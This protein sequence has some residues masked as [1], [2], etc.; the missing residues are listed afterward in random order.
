[1][2]LDKILVK[3]ACRTLSTYSVLSTS[4]QTAC[5]GQHFV[6]HHEGK[7]SL[8][9]DFATVPVL[10]AKFAIHQVKPQAWVLQQ[11]FVGLS[12]AL[13]EVLE[14]RTAFVTSALDTYSTAGHRVTG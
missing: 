2:F 9:R 10:S 4:K 14:N 8:T 1:M 7:A 13:P 11:A 3:T 5:S 12:P 6:M